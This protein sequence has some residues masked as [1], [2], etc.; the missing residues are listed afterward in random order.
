MLQVGWCFVEWW[1]Y[2]PF[3]NLVP[4]QV[5]LPVVKV[6]VM[7]YVVVLARFLMKSKKSLRRTRMMN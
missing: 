5:P 7:G 1:S 4:N 2:Q 3:G 6:V